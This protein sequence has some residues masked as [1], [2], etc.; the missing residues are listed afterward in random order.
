MLT[1]LLMATA[2]AAEVQV[3]VQSAVV[4]TVDGSPLMMNPGQNKVT[5]R[6]LGVGGHLV[7]ARS[8]FGKVLASEQV[9]LAEGEQLRLMYRKKAFTEV[10]RGPAPEAPA[11]GEA[12][13]A[14]PAAGL[15]AIQ[16]Q[17][18][19]I[20]EAAGGA[21]PGMGADEP[22]AEPATAPP[23][24]AAPPAPSAPAFSGDVSVAFTGLDPLM[25]GMIV[26]G[27]DLPW[28][29]ERQ[30]FV[31]TGL[32]PNHRYELALI[33]RGV[34]HLKNGFT[35]GEPGHMNCPVL[36]LTPITYEFA[37]CVE[38][39]AALGAAGAPAAPPPPS[40]IADAD[41]AALV[42][43]VDDESFSSDQLD[44]VRTAV[45][46]HHFLC[47]QVAQVIEPFAHDSDKVEALE[48]L[49]PKV[50]D[51]ANVGVIENVLSFSSDKEK[52][53]ALFGG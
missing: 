37:D 40:P 46:K 49:R 18:G 3:T 19:A 53:R 1:T 48:V 24:V 21:L 33:L 13:R 6:D 39:G 14:N 4:I 8:L 9:E 38:G 42:K 22:A 5:A 43:A 41:L 20:Q 34:S 31:V 30:A 26:A 29:R 35:T 25:H 12:K 10:G 7:E 47:R 32:E 51:P 36:M 2:F 15:K 16:E 11:E 17:L 27:K 50:L 45:G 52:V 23:P 44:L 28:D